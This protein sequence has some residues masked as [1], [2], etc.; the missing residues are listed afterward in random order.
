MSLEPFLL[1]DGV[2]WLVIYYVKRDHGSL[3]YQW[4][5]VSATRD[6]V[7]METCYHSLGAH[8]FL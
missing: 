7:F 3:Y 1:L 6:M 5:N 8:L 2:M 4:F